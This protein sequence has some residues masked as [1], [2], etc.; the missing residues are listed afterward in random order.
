MNVINRSENE[1]NGNGGNGNGGME[2][3]EMK[4]KWEFR[5][6]LEGS[7][8][9]LES[10]LSKTS[11]V[12]A[13]IISQEQK[14]DRLNPL[15]EKWRL[16]DDPEVY[17]PRNLKIQEDEMEW[18][19]LTKSPVGN[20]QG[21]IIMSVEDQTLG[22]DCPKVRNQNR[23]NQTRNKNGN[24]TGNQ[25]GGNETTA[26]AY[27]IGGGGT[28]PDSNVV[29]VHA[30]STPTTLDT[31]YAVELA[32]GR[33]SETNIVLRGCMLG[34]LGHP[35]DIDLM[36]VELGSFDIII[37]MDCGSKLNIISYTKTQK[38][39]EKGCQVYLAQV[40]SKKAED[41]SYRR[42]TLRIVNRTGYPNV[43]PEIA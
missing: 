32:D 33:I 28:N 4:W 30:G 5:V 36:P 20:Q 19:N 26:R 39:I 13:T 31:S 24:K 42:A 8:R 6:E 11:E 1:G 29:T 7:C 3:T 27:A 38:Y 9:W 18:W 23:G 43:F 17:C 14:R 15:F 34:L 16:F 2:K 25:T 12:Q 37:G 21:I 10:A 41:K 35:F 40:T 22:K